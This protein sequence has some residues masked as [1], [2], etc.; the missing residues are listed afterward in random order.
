MRPI[1]ASSSGSV[2]SVCGVRTGRPCATR[3]GSCGRR[4]NVE[5]D[6]A[7][8]AA[9]QIEPPTRRSPARTSR[10]TSARSLARVALASTSAA[11]AADSVTSCVVSCSS[12]E[13]R[14]STGM[15]KRRSRF[16]LSARMPSRNSAPPGSKSLPDRDSRPCSHSVIRMRS[17]VVRGICSRRATSDDDSGDSASTKSSS[18]SQAR[19]RLG[20]RYRSIGWRDSTGGVES[21]SSDVRPAGHARGQVRKERVG[22]HA[23]QGVHGHRQHRALAPRAERPEPHHVAGRAPRGPAVHLVVEGERQGDV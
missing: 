2:V 9:V 15:A 22:R 10:R 19:A 17:A 1:S 16:A 14:C 3:V 5:E 11:S 6:L 21:R 12:L 20:M 23:H 8:G 13:R 7:G 4:A 18:I